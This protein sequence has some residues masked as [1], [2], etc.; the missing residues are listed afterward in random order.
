[1]EGNL[2]SGRVGLICLLVAERALSLG[3]G[4]AAEIEADRLFPAASVA[5]S[6]MELVGR[7]VHLRAQLTVPRSADPPNLAALR[8]ET[9]SFLLASRSLDLASV[10]ALVRVNTPSMINAAKARFGEAFGQDYGFLSDIA[11]P[12]ASAVFGLS[13]EE[14]ASILTVIR[15]PPITEYQAEVLV[16]VLAIGLQSINHDVLNL[17]EWASSNDLSLLDI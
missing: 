2:L 9:V 4:L 13:G 1:V 17:M 12:N 11:H 14:E 3:E 15:R 16:K 7:L 6:L 5:R 8:Q 10:P